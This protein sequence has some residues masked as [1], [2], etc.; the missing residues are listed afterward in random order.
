LPAFIILHKLKNISPLDYRYSH[1]IVSFTKST[2]MPIV[3]SRSGASVAGD[4]VLWVDEYVSRADSGLLTPTSESFGFK[5]YI[6]RSAKALLTLDPFEYLAIFR[7]HLAEPVVSEPAQPPIKLQG[8]A[9]EEAKVLVRKAL[10]MAD[11]V[12]TQTPTIS[13]T[14]SETNATPDQPTITT[15]KSAPLHK[16]LITKLRPLPFQYVWSVYHEKHLP[17]SSPSP[18][19]T[20]STTNPSATYTDRLST[21]AP[22]VPD[23]GEFYKIFN[24]I[25]WHAIKSRDSIHIFRSGVAPLW[26]DAE[27]L[28]G[29]A[30]TLK[31]RKL[32]AIDRPK[33]VWEE[34]C[35]MGCGGELQAALAEAGSRDHVL[36]M[37]FSPR[38]YWVHVSIW[39]KKGADLTSRAVLQK[40]VLERLS[41]ELRPGGE[42]EYY[43]KMHCEHEGWE[44][45]VGRKEGE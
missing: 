30:W 9:K 25:P 17:S 39:M 28:S 32:D 18:T 33:R 38:L 29:G 10:G 22:T 8:H 43:Y 15:R 37:T 36:G 3:S 24:N 27:N 35:L 1:Q 21:L 14:G 26:E 42:A 45:A 7:D 34:I 12:I 20:S 11:P 5:T 13:I 16:N 6:P 19:S 4:K 31:V 44:E 41:P 2:I 23:I 40:T